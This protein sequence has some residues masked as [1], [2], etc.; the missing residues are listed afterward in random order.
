MTLSDTF[1]LGVLLLGTCGDLNSRLYFIANKAIE[2][3]FNKDQC[4][5][6][7][8][9][10]FFFEFISSIMFWIFSHSS[11]CNNCVYSF[12]C[13]PW[14]LSYFLFEHHGHQEGEW[15]YLESRKTSLKFLFFILAPTC[16]NEACNKFAWSVVYYSNMFIPIFG[17]S[18]KRILFMRRHLQ[19]C[20]ISF[21]I[22]NFKI[23]TRMHSR[24]S[25]QYSLM[26][27]SL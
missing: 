4:V 21:S 12:D 11:R 18:H 5:K 13:C 2:V 17:P 24:Y 14:Q 9:S 23:W 16:C 3:P 10:K 1:V 20:H 25:T 22:Q 15:E 8:L 19:F 26:N 7:R 6:T 27:Y